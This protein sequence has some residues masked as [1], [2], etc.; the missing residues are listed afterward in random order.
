[1]DRQADDVSYAPL[2]LQ[3]HHQ[4][5][6]SMV[7]QNSRHRPRYAQAS[8]FVSPSVAFYVSLILVVFC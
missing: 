5:T 8:Q 2:V 6:R 3:I 7:Y 4:C 1:M